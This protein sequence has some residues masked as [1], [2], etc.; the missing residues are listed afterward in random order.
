MTPASCWVAHKKLESWAR[1]AKER[2]IGGSTSP[3]QSKNGSTSTG[4]SNSLEVTYLQLSV[5]KTNYTLQRV[6]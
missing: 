2:A 6:V 5:T 3:T 1:A 4:S